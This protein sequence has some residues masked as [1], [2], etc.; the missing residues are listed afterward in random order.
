MINNDDSFRKLSKKTDERVK[1]K[2]DYTMNISFKNLTLTLKSNGKIV[3]DNV[4]GVLNSGTVT[5]IMGPSGM[6]K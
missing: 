6:L 5:A 4:S 1:R 2:L 3:V